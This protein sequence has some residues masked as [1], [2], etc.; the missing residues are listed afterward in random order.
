VDGQGESRR[1][2]FRIAV[3]RT[4][5]SSYVLS[6]GIGLIFVLVG[7]IQISP[8]QLALLIGCALASSLILSWLVIQGVLDG[9]SHEVHHG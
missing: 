7:V 3:Q 5:T 1:R 2:R 6:G 4:R 9:A 8:L